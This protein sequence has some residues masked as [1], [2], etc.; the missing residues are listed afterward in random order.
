MDNPEDN[1]GG[2]FNSFF[3]APEPKTWF[4][5]EAASKEA[6][7]PVCLACSYYLAIEDGLCQYCVPK[8]AES[9]ARMFAGIEEL[10]TKHMDFAR[11]CDGNEPRPA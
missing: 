3:N 11:W 1:F 10:L 5:S 9:V 4:D 6:Q 8:Q 2:F 7:E